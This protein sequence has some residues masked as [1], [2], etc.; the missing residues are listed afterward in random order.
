M[1]TYSIKI[2][3]LSLS[4][5]Q[6][7]A[8]AKEA[9]QLES[10]YQNRQYFELRDELAKLKNDKSPDVLF[11]RAAVANKF[12]EPEKSVKY[13]QE[14]LKKS[15]ES[16]N[17][18]GAYELLADNYTKTCEYG[19][20]AATYKILLDK[21]KDKVSEA[22]A[23]GYENLF[24][25]WNAL[26]AS[27]RQ[28]VTVKKDT[29][30]KGARDKAR[31]L[32]IPVEAGSQ[33]MDFVFDTGANLSTMTVSTAKKLG[34]RI[35][36]SDVSVGSSTDKNVK[37]KLAVAPELKIG[38]VVVK[39]VVF[40]VL[41]DKSLYFQSIDYQINAIIGFPVI[42]SLGR[43]T[44]TRDDKIFVAA[45]NEKTKAEPNMLLEGL[46]PLA[47]GTYNGKR[48]LFS[49]DT[50]AT[51]S[52]LYRAFYEAEK[53]TILKQSAPEKVRFGGA[54]G[55]SEVTAHKLKDLDLEI[56]GKTARFPKINV[57]TESV[58]TWS[59][60]YYGNLGQDLIKQ[61]ERM[62]LDFNAMRLV[63]E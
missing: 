15:G 43:I 6:I 45:K 24:G 28:T 42:K 44:L 50:G 16:K 62:T 58:N 17:L 56:G 4:L 37:S 51:A 23:R 55:Y 3:L 57:L 35:I 2:L 12:N 47:A 53:E 33:K 19:K 8:F 22:E 46:L 18:R 39:N 26:A 11:Y 41:E 29:E 38:D 54:G 52:S 21:Y 10:L 59:R 14:F 5:L 36:E 7:F 30:I 48:M 34:L 1:K 25:L 49:F 40:L 31:L 13:L 32:N 9:P 63:F 61:F 27:P 20:A 60:Y